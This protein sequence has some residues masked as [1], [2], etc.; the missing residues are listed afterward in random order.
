MLNR[1]HFQTNTKM[2]NTNQESPTA[3]NFRASVHYWQVVMQEEIGH[4]W[5]GFLGMHEYIIQIGGW[6]YPGGL[7]PLYPCSRVLDETGGKVTINKNALESIVLA[8]N[9]EQEMSVEHGNWTEASFPAKPPEVEYSP[10]E[11]ERIKEEVF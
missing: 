11:L 2:G 3:T 4:G 7:F 1:V 6:T 8:F 10:D 9:A 5:A